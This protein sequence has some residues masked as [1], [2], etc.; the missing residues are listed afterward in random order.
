M[1]PINNE[2]SFINGPATSNSTATYFD[3]NGQDNNENLVRINKRNCQIGDT[4]TEAINEKLWLAVSI[5]F[6]S[7]ISEK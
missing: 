4:T 5:N 2:R 7:A 1:I 3:F 6:M